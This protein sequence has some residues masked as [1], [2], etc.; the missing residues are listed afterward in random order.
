MSTQ[1]KNIAIIGANEFQ[2]PLILTVKAM[3]Y[4]T[5][6]FAWQAG[7][8]GEK[9]ADYFY[10]ISIVELDR[11][12]EVCRKLDLAG[13]VS[14]GSDLASI[15]V[16]YVAEQLGLT[17]NGMKSALTATNKHWMR[18]AFEKAGLPSCKSCLVSSPE[19]AEALDL[20]YPVIVKPTDRSGSRGIFK[21]TEDNPL[22]HAVEQAMA[23]SFEK[24]V[25]NSRTGTSSHGK[26]P[27]TERRLE[28]RILPIPETKRMAPSPRISHSSTD[29]ILPTRFTPP[30]AALAAM[31]TRTTEYRGLSAPPQ[32]RICVFGVVNSKNSPIPCQIQN[33]FR[34]HNPGFPCRWTVRSSRK[35]MATAGSRYCH[36]VE[37]GLCSS[38]KKFPANSNAANRYSRLSC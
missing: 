4:T 26:S 3:G 30:S 31:R 5:H 7:D 20:P 1:K 17:G 14:I 32:D 29:A 18:L 11:I 27:C 34:S 19:E 9:T 38:R 6:V 24:K 21:V 35:P 22:R 10:P 15:T 37:H 23:L 2:N 13:I 33:H 12:L 8:I 28:S 25:G 36:P 16:N